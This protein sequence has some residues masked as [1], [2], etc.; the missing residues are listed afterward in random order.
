MSV[1]S[2]K[3]MTK[4]TLAKLHAESLVEPVDHS[5]QFP[6]ELDDYLDGLA[7]SMDLLPD[8]S[9]VKSGQSDLFRLYL[10]GLAVR[11]D[12]A[13]AWKSLLTDWRSA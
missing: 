12:M 11:N 7:Q 3:D 8:E 9:D 2:K 5:E 1:A 4:N 10:D 6:Q 13:V